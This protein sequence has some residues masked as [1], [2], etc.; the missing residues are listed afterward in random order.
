MTPNP[1]K[2]AEIAEIGHF[3]PPGA[4]E[5]RPPTLSER[6]DTIRA[7]I[8]PIRAKILSES[9]RIDQPGSWSASMVAEMALD[10]AEHELA[11]A[12]LSLGI[13]EDLR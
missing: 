13:Q 4:P 8:E 7:S 11:I 1:P 9:V 12:A 10:R 5:G 2:S 3:P 6:I